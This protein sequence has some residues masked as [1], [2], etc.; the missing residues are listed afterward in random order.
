MNA[1][2]C[3]GCEHFD[4]DYCGYWADEIE[5]VEECEEHTECKSL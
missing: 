2:F 1:G 4:F 3:D 5:L